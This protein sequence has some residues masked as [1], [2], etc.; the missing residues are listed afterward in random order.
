MILISNFRDQKNDDLTDGSDLG[1][2]CAPSRSTALPVPAGENQT[3]SEKCLRV[4][5]SHLKLPS[6]WRLRGGVTSFV[7]FAS[8]KNVP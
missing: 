5:L 4:F 7:V 6:G 3:G 1:E 8:G 2:R